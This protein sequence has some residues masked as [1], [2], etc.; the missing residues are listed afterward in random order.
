M[1]YKYK[2]AKA[3][4]LNNTPDRWLKPTAIQYLSSALLVCWHEL[5]TRDSLILLENQFFLLMIALTI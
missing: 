1:F 2:W 4:I 5:Q 3:Q